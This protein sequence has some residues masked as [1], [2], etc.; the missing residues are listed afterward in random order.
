[1]KL[2]NNSIVGAV[3]A[4]GLSLLAAQAQAAPVAGVT[5]GFDFVSL[6]SKV[7]LPT[8]KAQK[9]TPAGV[10]PGSVTLYKS[11]GGEAWFPVSGGAVDTT[12]FKFD[13]DHSGGLSLACG[14][15]TVDMTAL[16]FDSASK[17]VTGI[18]VV[19][20]AANSQGG[21][22]SGRLPLFTLD[23][24]SAKNKTGKGTV[25]ISGVALSLTSGAVT[26]L[27]TAFNGCGALPT[28]STIPVGTATLLLF[29][30]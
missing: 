23:L 3:A 30:K 7:F 28:G 18:V 1:M 27:N 14:T 11:G 22:L 15:T 13:A 29:V 10:K 25:S 4:A 20:D 19:D 16:A 8:L 6:D 17:T 21:D 9:I 2:L 5:L 24:T 26:A 12:S